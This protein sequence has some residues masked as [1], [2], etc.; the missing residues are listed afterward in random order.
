M[1]SCRVVSL[2]YPGV[3]E[4]WRQHLLSHSDTANLLL[5]ITSFVG[6]VLSEPSANDIVI[7]IHKNILDMDFSA[8]VT[9]VSTGIEPS[10]ER[11][12]SVTTFDLLYRSM[13]NTFAYLNLFVHNTDEIYSNVV[14]GIIRH[15]R[16]YRSRKARIRR[17]EAILPLAVCSQT[18]VNNVDRKIHVTFKDDDLLFSSFRSRIADRHRAWQQ[19]RNNFGFTKSNVSSQL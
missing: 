6:P 8:A 18:I 15:I 14:L 7:L 2:R 12:K 10:Q 3:L 5:V 9:L 17:T 19:V 4:L 13:D 1:N 11:S 16:K